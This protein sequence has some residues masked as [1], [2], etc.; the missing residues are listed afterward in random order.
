MSVRQVASLEDIALTAFSPDAPSRVGVAVSGGSDS[1]AALHLIAQVVPVEAVTIDHG[2]RAEAAAEA[3]FVAEACARLSVPHSVI[4]WQRTETAGNLMDQA[5]RARL[6]LIGDWARARGLSHVVLGHT[7]D[8]QAETFLMRL[9]RAAGLE[10][11]SGMRR[12]W[13]ENGVNWTRPF[14]DVPR[15]TLRDWLR[16]R[17]IGWIDDPTNDNEDYDRVKARKA[18]RALAPL[19]LS[20]ERI[21]DVVAH[22]GDAETAVQDCLRRAVTTLAREDRGDVVISADAFKAELPAELQR[23]LIVQALKWV[24]GQDYAPRADA[25]AGLLSGV[26]D[27]R[28]GTL[29]GCR[30]LVTEA[31]IRIT[32]EWQAVAALRAPV[33]T[34]WDRWLLNGPA[35]AGQEVAALGETGLPMCPQWRETGMPRAS[36]LASPAV[37][38]G[39]KLVAAPLA[40]LENGWKA[41]IVRGSFKQKPFSH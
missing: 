18:L 20:A 19:G 11:L 9:A 7:A 4:R 38:Q 13:A 8:D 3:R 28:G 22:L 17:N 36:L 40:G 29:A 12:N 2:L 1:M 5:R 16:G 10:G 30:I 21:C 31:E 41:R 25:V 33:G 14:L 23:R 39:E 15:A 27:G 34:P 32:R 37:W 6:R 26:S 35:A 24:G